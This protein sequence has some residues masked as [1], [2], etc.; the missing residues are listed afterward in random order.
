MI[1]WHQ[2]FIS[3]WVQSGE[4]RVEPVSQPSTRQILIRKPRLPEHRAQSCCACGVCPKGLGMLHW[5][6]TGCTPHGVPGRFSSLP[7][8]PFQNFQGSSPVEHPGFPLQVCLQSH[9]FIHCLVSGCLWELGTQTTLKISMKTSVTLL[10]PRSWVCT[11]DVTHAMQNPVTSRL[12][13]GSLHHSGI[14]EFL[15]NAAEPG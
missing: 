12:H 13:Q 14:S 2:H 3:T 11:A 7:V 4:D 8:V 9:S 10:P 5:N 1:V 15:Y 6:L